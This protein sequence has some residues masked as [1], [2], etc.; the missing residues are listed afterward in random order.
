MLTG[1]AADTHTR[2]RV[3]NTL[4][5]LLLKLSPQLEGG[6]Q[7]REWYM[8]DLVRLSVTMTASGPIDSSFASVE[9]WRG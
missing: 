5:H 3:S 9:A 8:L 4:L 6:R 2:I 1:G 7:N